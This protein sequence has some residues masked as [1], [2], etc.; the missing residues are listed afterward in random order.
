[1]YKLLPQK[2]GDKARK[3]YSLRRVSVV[4]GLISTLILFTI[5]AL[6]PTVIFLLEKKRAALFTLQ[7][8]D[9]P[10]Q[11]L[12]KVALERWLDDTLADLKIIT[13]DD[14]RDEP[15]AYF[16]KILAERS[17]SISITNLAFS[18]APNGAKSL[19]ASGVAKTR[20]ALI[21]FQADLNESGEWGQVDFPV[22]AIARE[23][24]IPFE[25]NL[26]PPKTK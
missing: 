24:D 25:I 15:Y 26:T 5:V 6:S 23:A 3:E 22:G 14:T 8:V 7:V 11:G 17:S 16:Q 1:M 9:K 10:A 21:A 2:A 18:K 13:P 19:R 20:Q 12:D 4:L